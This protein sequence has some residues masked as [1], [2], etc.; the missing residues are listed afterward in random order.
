MVKLVNR[1]ITTVSTGVIAHQ[2][3]CQGVMG[4]GIA[5]A[6]RDRYQI[7]YPLYK[8]LC[9]SREDYD[10]L[11]LMQLIQVTDTLYIS[12]VFGQL[13]YG[14]DASVIYTN[15]EALKVSLNKLF[16]SASDKKLD[17]YIPYK[18]GCGL[19][20]GDWNVVLNIINELDALYDVNI[21]I[22]R[23]I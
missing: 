11:G 19:A 13:T 21:Y 9:I 3:N 10:L 1:D 2:V 14:K 12:N 20:N 17:V 18:I 6:L 5:K 4:A 8:Q 23:K 22:C 15:Y 16:E 7:L